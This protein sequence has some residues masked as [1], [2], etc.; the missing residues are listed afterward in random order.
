MFK[1]P[2]TK[3]ALLLDD[4]ALF[5]H[6]GVV[7]VNLAGKSPPNCERDFSEL[8]LRPQS[9]LAASSDDIPLIDRGNAVRCPLLPRAAGL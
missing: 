9:A 8:G 1:R 6:E 4:A 5:T 2:S 7:P 3:A